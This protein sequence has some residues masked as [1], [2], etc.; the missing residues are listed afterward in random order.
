MNTRSTAKT[1]T[2]GTRPCRCP[3]GERG[4]LPH[5][6]LCDGSACRRRFVLLAIDLVPDGSSCPYG[7]VT[8]DRGGIE[9][10]NAC[11]A[12]ATPAADNTGASPRRKAER[13]AVEVICTSRA[14]ASTHSSRARQMTGRTM[15]C[16]SAGS[17]PRTATAAS[18]EEATSFSRRCPF[19]RNES[20]RTSTR[21]DH[22]FV[23]MTTTPP[24]PTAMW[25]MLAR[26]R[27]GQRRSCKATQ[28]SALRV[29]RTRLVA[30]SPLAARLEDGH[31]APGCR[32][33]RNPTFRHP[34]RRCRLWAP[35]T[36][37]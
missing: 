29:S 1:S 24:G 4:R 32:E 31:V 12:L 22:F 27:P 7:A 3:L 26:G 30:I 16:R 28:P 20:S 19:C 23:S 35:A 13:L 34:Q 9:R 6:C 17:S 37:G 14:V 5:G 11:T 8:A 36:A 33:R 18:A 21:P 10:S 25:S 15:G 2:S